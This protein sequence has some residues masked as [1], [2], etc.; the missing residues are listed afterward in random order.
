[1]AWVRGLQ[2]KEDLLHYMPPENLTQLLKDWTWE[3]ARRVC[4]NVCSDIKI[5]SRLE[6]ASETNP[7]TWPPPRIFRSPYSFRHMDTWTCTHTNVQ[8]LF[9]VS[10]LVSP[11]APA[12]SISSV[13]HVTGWRCDSCPYA[14]PSLAKVTTHTNTLIHKRY[15]GAPLQG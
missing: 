15:T 2:A 12:S 14:R 8:T 1:M 3:S 11:D 4:M 10:V 5:L 13:L 6:G 7:F 9:L